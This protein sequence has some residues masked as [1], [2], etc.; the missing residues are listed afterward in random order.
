MAPGPLAAHGGLPGGGGFLSGALHPFVAVPHLILLLG[1]GLVSARLSAE[2]RSATFAAVGFGLL[3]GV[4]VAQAGLQPPAKAAAAAILALAVLV[5]VLAALAPSRLPAL[6]V[7][8]VALPSGFAVGLDTDLAAAGVGISALIAPLVGVVAGVY[9]IVL[10]S[11]AVAAFA[12][13]RPALVIVPRVA[14]SW[15]A[16]IGLMLLT[17]SLAP[18]R[19]AG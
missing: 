13:R 7:A 10:D 2:N 6:L 18:I 12:Q 19:P 17:L 1:L 4:A 15:I 8:G 11:A 14:G 16:A 5:G 9:L 3:A